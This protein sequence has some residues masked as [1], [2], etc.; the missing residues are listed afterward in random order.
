MT[1]HAVVVRQQDDFGSSDRD[2][3]RPDGDAGILNRNLEP[4]VEAVGLERFGAHDARRFSEHHAQRSAHRGHVHGPP[5]AIQDESRSLQQVCSPK[6]LRGTHAGY[7]AAKPFANAGGAEC[8]SGCQVVKPSAARVSCRRGRFPASWEFAVVACSGGPR[9]TFRPSKRRHLPTHLEKQHVRAHSI[10]VWRLRVA[11]LMRGSR[12]TTKT[13]LTALLTLCCLLPTACQM[14]P[15]GPSEV[16]SRQFSDVVVPDGF[17]I[18][19]R[20]HE[21]YSREEATWRHGRF[22]YAGNSYVAE[23]SAYVRGQM[24]RHSWKLVSQQPIDDA[25]VRLRFERGIYSADYLFSR[26][27]GTTHMVVDY[28]TDYSRR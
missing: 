10:P 6:C 25:G 8:M 18:T 23:A 16:D 2:P 9:Y 14:A 21:S 7:P 26:R 3:R 20:T 28:A 27:D 5:R 19:D 22:Q 13:M 17:R 1:R 4:A 15:D 11:H 12:M 24:P